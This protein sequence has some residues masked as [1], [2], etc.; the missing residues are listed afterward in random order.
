ME[1]FFFFYFLINLL[2][3]IPVAFAA[4]QRTAKQWHSFLLC[5]L[6]SPILALLYILCFPT[7]N[8]VEMKDKMIVRL[9]N[10]VRKLDDKEENN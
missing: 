8:E 5:L 10:I 7:R 4:D 6:I 3:C 9:D 1:T 2:C